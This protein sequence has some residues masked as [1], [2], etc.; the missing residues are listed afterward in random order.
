MKLHVRDQL[1]RVVVVLDVEVVAEGHVPSHVVA[2]HLGVA[3]A[4]AL[5]LTR[6]CRGRA[7]CRRRSALGGGRALP[8]L[9]PRPRPWGR[10]RAGGR[11][12]GG[13]AAAAACAAGG[14]A[15][16][17][18]LLHAAR[19]RAQRRRVDGLEHAGPDQVVLLLQGAPGRVGGRRRQRE[20][21]GVVH[22]RQRVAQHVVLEAL[23][24]VLAADVQGDQ[25]GRG[26]GLGQRRRCAARQRGG[27]GPHPQFSK[28]N[29]CTASVSRSSSRA[30]QCGCGNGRRRNAVND[31]ATGAQRT[32]AEGRSP[33]ACGPWGAA[34]PTSSTENSL[35]GDTRYPASSGKQDSS[36]PDAKQFG[37]R[38]TASDAALI[39]Y[40]ESVIFC[41]GR[42]RQ[43]G[44]GVR[45]GVGGVHRA[46]GPPN[47]PAGP[48]LAAVRALDA[49]A[50]LD[51]F[52]LL[53]PRVDRGV[54]AESGGA[55]VGP[56]APR[57]GPPHAAD[58]P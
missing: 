51:G 48:H 40:S 28:P 45:H 7:R 57:L 53:Q 11:R 2:H 37:Q 25:P 10:G 6:P 47:A 29:C 1:L 12:M 43:A 42:R 56:R 27:A 41:A 17:G 3:A 39:K 19:H 8:R 20:A 34:P 52:A 23:L 32:P 21:A 18:Q 9:L 58:A 49:A 55:G 24:R 50:I 35:Q 13:A 4:T 16:E 15:G 31:A 44:S 26:T 14:A 54:C 38:T 30:V 46:T 36:T 33:E 5:F 22:P